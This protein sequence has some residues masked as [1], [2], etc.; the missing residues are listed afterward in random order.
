MHK[1]SHRIDTQN[2]T[3]VEDNMLWKT[4]PKGP[5]QLIDLNWEDN[6]KAQLLLKNATTGERI[7][8]HLA[9]VSLTLHLGMG[10]DRF[11]QEAAP[12]FMILAFCSCSAGGCL[13]PHQFSSV[14]GHLY[15]ILFLTSLYMLCH[16]IPRIFN[17]SS[18]YF[19]CDMLLTG[20]TL[21]K[22]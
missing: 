3:K 22:R 1:V 12:K 6:N 14:Q 7:Q 19:K 9:H 8:R 20:Q 4:N 10:C 17:S 2:A 21:Q 13:S 16:H 18:W 15:A 11:K 5:D